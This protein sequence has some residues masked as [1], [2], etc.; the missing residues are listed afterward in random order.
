MAGV[1]YSLGW[2]LACWAAGRR[3]NACGLMCFLVPSLMVLYE[4]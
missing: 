3:H 2:A 4:L 1:I